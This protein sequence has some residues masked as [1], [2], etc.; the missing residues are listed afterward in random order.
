MSTVKN[1][2]AASVRQAKTQPPMKTPVAAKAPPGKP[3]AGKA[4]AA[5]VQPPDPVASGG[6]PASSGSVL[7]PSRVW[8]D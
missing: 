1:K 2:L 8:P 5:R 4:P 6:E 7:F 3:A